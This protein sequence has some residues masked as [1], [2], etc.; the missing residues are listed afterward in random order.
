MWNLSGTF[1]FPIVLVNGCCG[2][3]CSVVN[4][5]EQNGSSKA[6]TLNTM[7]IIPTVQFKCFKLN[8]K[9]SI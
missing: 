8:L 5:L 6:K 2:N 3:S 9:K 7:Q 4:R 1:Q